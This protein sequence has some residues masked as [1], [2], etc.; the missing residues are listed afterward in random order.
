MESAFI[1]GISHPIY[2]ARSYMS[3]TAGQRVGGTHPTLHSQKVT[4]PQIQVNR[5][6]CASSSNHVA[7]LRDHHLKRFQRFYTRTQKAYQMQKESI[8]IKTIY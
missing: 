1:K 7:F 5:C 2:F 8:L 6:Q 3:L 4:E